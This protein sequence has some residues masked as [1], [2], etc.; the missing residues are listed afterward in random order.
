MCIW[1]YIWIVG[2]TLHIDRHAKKL[3]EKRANAR[4]FAS[5]A[6]H[7]MG[8]TLFW[9]HFLIFKQLFLTKNLSF[10]HYRICTERR[11]KWGEFRGMNQNRTSCSLMRGPKGQL[12]SKRL[13]WC[14]QLLPKYERKQVDLRYYSS[15][16][17]FFRSFFGRIEDTKKSFWN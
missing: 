7:T 6:S 4:P 2:W 12:T 17:K 5:Q 9:S 14:L 1:A 8:W 11:R 16:V 15:K 3:Q 13:F 10:F